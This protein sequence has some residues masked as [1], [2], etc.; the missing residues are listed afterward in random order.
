MRPVYLAALARYRE[1]VDSF[2]EALYGPAATSNAATRANL[3]ARRDYWHRRISWI[4]R[5][6]RVP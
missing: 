4:L 1:Y 3:R 6:L 2:G 5:R